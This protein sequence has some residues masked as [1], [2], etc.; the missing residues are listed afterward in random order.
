M[1]SRA[2]IILTMLCV[3]L[4]LVGLSCGAPKARLTVKAV[5]ED[6][7]PLAGMS[8]VVGF[9]NMSGGADRT[10]L[11]GLTDSNGLFAAEGKAES[12]DAYYLVRNM[13]CYESSGK[14]EFAN[15]KGRKW[16]PWNPTVT[17]VVRRVVHPIPMY[18][19]NVGVIIPATNAPCGYDLMVGDWV[20]PHGKGEHGDLIFTI[21]MR[22]VA[23]WTDCEGTLLMSFSSEKDGIRKRDGIVVGGSSFPWQYMAPE[24]GYSGAVQVYM[25]YASGKGSF[26]TNQSSACYFRVRTVANEEGNIVSAYYG[27]ISGPLKFDVRE[28]DTGW[29]AFTYYLNPTPNGRNMEFDPKRNLFRNLKSTEQVNYP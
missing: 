14:Y 18:V 15:L 8:A 5:S 21:G 25:G 20:A 9:W 29:V 17:A 13:G 27:K 11:T 6:G 4:G 23:S 12:L 28:S 24:E 1:N 16:Q 22:R 7:K 26:E 3:L 10:E 2:R 19:K